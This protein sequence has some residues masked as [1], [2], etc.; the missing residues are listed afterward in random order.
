MSCSVCNGVGM[1][2]VCEDSGIDCRIC[3]GAG[4]DENG[5][6]CPVCSGLGYVDEDNEPDWDNIRDERNENSY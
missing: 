5:H 2:P 6:M 1:C 3:D 4:Y